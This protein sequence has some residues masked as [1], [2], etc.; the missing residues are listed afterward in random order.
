LTVPFPTARPPPK[1]YLS[2]SIRTQALDEA[3]AAEARGAAAA[4][5]AAVKT[6]ELLRQLAELAAQNQRLL[7]KQAKLTHA[8]EVRSLRIGRFGGLGYADVE[9]GPRTGHSA[10]ICAAYVYPSVRD[11]LVMYRAW[12][13]VEKRGA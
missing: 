12:A 1:S 11:T 7:D 8:N 2:G 6:A 5:A 4:A 3:R 10:H 9:K 13:D